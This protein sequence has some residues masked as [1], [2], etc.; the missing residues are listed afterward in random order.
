MY[1]KFHLPRIFSF[2]CCILAKSEKKREEDLF[3]FHFPRIFLFFVVHSSKTE[4][5]GEGNLF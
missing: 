3:K 4:K 5:K 1:F 2:L